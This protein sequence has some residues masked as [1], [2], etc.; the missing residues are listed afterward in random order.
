[1]KSRLDIYN[2]S[3]ESKIPHSSSY[4]AIIRFMRAPWKVA[5]LLIWY[6]RSTIAA[7]TILV[8]IIRIPSTAKRLYDVR[9]REQ[10]SKA[11][12]I[13]WHSE[14]KRDNLFYSLPMEIQ[15]MIMRKLDN[16][17]LCRLSQ[18]CVKIRASSMDH[19]LWIGKLAS[20]WPDYSSKSTN[21]RIQKASKL[22]ANFE[23]NKTAQ[24]IIATKEVDENPRTSSSPAFQFYRQ[25]SITYAK[26]A[27]K[28]KMGNGIV[29]VSDTLLEEASLAKRKFRRPLLRVHLFYYFISI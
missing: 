13:V 10:R 15:H 25:R 9:I 16:Q 29:T 26:F 21:Q 6:T 8:T 11:F 7:I 2:Y 24:K 19:W 28:V 18:S 5:S 17:T 14:G 22:C 3:A 27:G 1:M 23:K 4:S 20:D 12:E